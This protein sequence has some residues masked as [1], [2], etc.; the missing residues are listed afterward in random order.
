MGSGPN[1]PGP[2]LPLFQG[3]QLVTKMVFQCLGWCTLYFGCWIWDWG[4]AFCILDGLSDIA[5]SEFH[6]LEDNLLLGVDDLKI[7][8]CMF[9]GTFAIFD[10][11]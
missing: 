9:D 8:F 11:Y 5:Y 4:G 1:C 10:D 7:F 6:I 3:G 2:N